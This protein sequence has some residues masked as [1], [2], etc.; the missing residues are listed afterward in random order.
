MALVGALGPPALLRAM[1]RGARASLDEAG[2]ASLEEALGHRFKDRAHLA[3]ALTHISAVT[4][5]Q[6]SRARVRSYQRL[7]FLGDHVLGLVVSDMLYRAYPAA[8]EGELSRRLADLVCEDSCAEVA[9]AMGV[10]AYIR[11]GAGE[12]RS[13]GR[14]R[15]AILADIAESV[16]A[17]VYLDAGFTAAE[18][19]VERFWR[20]RLRLAGGSARDPKTALQEWAQ[21]RGLPPPGY[22]LVERSGPDHSPLF[23]IAVEVPGFASVEADGPSKQNAQKAAA[24]AFLEQVHA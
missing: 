22:R 21:A 8:E 3:L 5:V 17:A 14:D 20:P 9:R 6:G 2:L 15:P 16:L 11:L 1:T 12:D 4:G 7:E 19:L 24:A 23:R 13:G 10:G 18:V